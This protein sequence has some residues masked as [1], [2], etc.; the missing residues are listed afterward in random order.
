MFPSDAL[1][2]ALGEDSF[3]HDLIPVWVNPDDDS[4]I[5]VQNPLDLTGSYSSHVLDATNSRLEI[6]E[7]YKDAAKYAAALGFNS[8]QHYGE[9]PDNFLSPIRHLNT[10]CFQGHMLTKD[11]DG[12][13]TQVTVNTGHWG[14]NVYP[15]CRSVRNGENAFLK[16]MEYEKHSMR[17]FQ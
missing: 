8:L 12:K 15:G 5:S 1:P 16:D 4:K 9:N 6:K 10:V 13:Y 2:A 11:A 14:P 17:A 3:S 7:H